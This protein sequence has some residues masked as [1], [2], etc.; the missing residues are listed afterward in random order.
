MFKS[1][2]TFEPETLGAGL[3][4]TDWVNAALLIAH[5]VPVHKLYPSQ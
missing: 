4:L 1:F 5:A 3:S 2:C